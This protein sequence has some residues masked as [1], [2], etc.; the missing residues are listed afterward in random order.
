[1]MNSCN[2]KRSVKNHEKLRSRQPSM[3]M[4]QLQDLSPNT[5]EEISEKQLYKQALAKMNMQV[6]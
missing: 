1:M 6:K 2:Q 5:I 4:Q 3:N